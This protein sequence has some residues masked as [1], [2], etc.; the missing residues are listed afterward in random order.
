MNTKKRFE[1][2]AS[3]FGLIIGSQFNRTELHG[4]EVD[5]NGRVIVPE[6]RPR[7]V[8]TVALPAF[9]RKFVSA[10][11]TIS[12]YELPPKGRTTNSYSI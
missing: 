3:V 2:A 1:T 6:F 11:L 5:L 7:S 4:F 9:R 12:G 10:W 8:P